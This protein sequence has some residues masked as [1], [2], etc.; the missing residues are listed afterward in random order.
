MAIRSSGFIVK[1]FENETVGTPLSRSNPMQ[2]D[3]RVAD[4]RKRKKKMETK[5][6]N[7]RPRNVS[8]IA[9]KFQALG[10]NIER[11]LIDNKSYQRRIFMYS[12]SI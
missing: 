1:F 2:T 7:R 3:L 5:R 12:K 8:T 9:T 6:E 10:I 4:R 11:S